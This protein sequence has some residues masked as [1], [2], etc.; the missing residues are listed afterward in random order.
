MN[1]SSTSKSSGCSFSNTL[2]DQTPVYQKATKRV[3]DR[4]WGIH[5]ARKKPVKWMK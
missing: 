4:T 3:Y 1:K 2:V 5:R